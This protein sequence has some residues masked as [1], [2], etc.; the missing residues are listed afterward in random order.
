MYVFVAIPT[1]VG[2]KKP[3]ALTEIPRPQDSAESG[4]QPNAGGQPPTRIV[5]SVC[6]IA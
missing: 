5:Y 1:V 3:K 6:S 2:T 4:K